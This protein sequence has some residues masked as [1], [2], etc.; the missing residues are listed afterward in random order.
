MRTG[1]E[2]LDDTEGQSMV[3]TRFKETDR[4]FLEVT[5]RTG[6]GRSVVGL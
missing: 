3:Q 4:E 5:H 6:K 2:F 1:D